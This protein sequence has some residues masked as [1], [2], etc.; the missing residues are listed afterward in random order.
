ME[1]RANELPVKRLPRRWYR[2][3]QPRCPRPLGSS[4]PD[5]GFCGTLGPGTGPLIEKTVSAQ[6]TKRCGG[7]PV[8]DVP[9]LCSAKN[10]PVG[11]G[12]GGQPDLLGGL[13]YVT[14]TASP[15]DRS[16]K[17]P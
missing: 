8:R 6:Q 1:W 17:V 13:S 11:I 5:V 10:D 14:S 12:L 2:A 9:G 7:F 16:A 4:A 15:C 3:A